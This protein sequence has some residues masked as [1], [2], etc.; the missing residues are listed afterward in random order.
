MK[1]VSALP[2]LLLT[3]L[4]ACRP[5][6]PLKSHAFEQDFP[7]LFGIPHFVGINSDSTNF[8]EAQPALDS[9]LVQ[10]IDIHRPFIPRAI[11]KMRLGETPWWA[12]ITLLGPGEASEHAQYFLLPFDSAAG[13]VGK[14]VWMTEVTSECL[15]DIHACEA[16]LNDT[17][18]DGAVELIR[19]CVAYGIP[20]PGAEY[21]AAGYSPVYSTEVLSFENGAFTPCPTCT[22]DTLQFPMA[23][24]SEMRKAFQTSGYAHMLP[25]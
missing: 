7:K 25:R 15:G 16:W 14:P 21:C 18:G 5:S 6:Q 13:K 24:T 23:Q 20:N 9:S 8:I 19:R 12:L 2:F 4:L 1:A 3:Y 17:N 10:A 11:G 22:I